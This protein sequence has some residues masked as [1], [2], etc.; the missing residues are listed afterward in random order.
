MPSTKTIDGTRSPPPNENK[1]SPNVLLGRRVGLGVVESSGH[2]LALVFQHS[3]LRR[4]HFHVDIHLLQRVRL[5]PSMYEECNS[6]RGHRQ[7]NDSPRRLDFSNEKQCRPTS[8]K[9]IQGE[10][11]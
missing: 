9:K 10:E 7:N 2:V 5:S 3:C 4:F 11:V 1:D 6:E 8:Q